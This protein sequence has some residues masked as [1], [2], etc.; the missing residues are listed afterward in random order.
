MKKILFAYD[1]IRP[2]QKVL[3]DDISKALLSHAHHLAHAPTGLGKTAASLAPAITYALEH[4]KV[5]FFLTSRHTQHT[6]AID[7]IR[8]IKQKHGVLIPTVDIIGRQKMCPV[9]GVQSLYSREFNE[10]CK[11][12]RADGTC[13]FYTNTWT[14]KGTLTASA[15]ASLGSL[16]H[17][18]PLHVEELSKECAKSKLCPYE[19]SL[20]LAKK[21]RVIVADYYYLFNPNI[22]DVLLARIN[23]SLQDCIVIVDEAHNL[24]GRI[25]E[26]MT[27]RISL[28]SIRRAQKEAQKH[29]YGSLAIFLENLYRSFVAFGK[30]SHHA[31]QLIS[32][33]LLISEVQS[34]GDYE[35]VIESLDDAAAEVRKNQKQS[36]L[37]SVASFLED[38]QGSDEGY[39]R[40]LSR[41]SEG[42]QMNVVLSY[43]C[44]DPSLVSND[45]INQSH[46]LILMSGTLTPVDMYKDILGF[47][48]DATTGE[49]ASPFSSKNRL[50][51]VNPT[52]TTK[53]SSR[54]DAEFLRIAT[55]CSEITDSI[56]GNSVIFF[57]SYGIKDI[58]W[59][60]LMRI[61]KKTMFQETKNLSKDER[62]DLLKEFKAYSKKGAVL[63]AVA[64]GSFGE[65]IDLPGDYLKGVVVVGLPL[66]PP[67][68]TVKQLIDYYQK[69]F[70]RG[71]DY[72]YTLPAITKSL[73][74]AGRCIRTEKDRG[75]IVFLEKRF[76][77]PQYFRCFPH[78][79]DVKITQDQAMAIK[80]FFSG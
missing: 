42:Q 76:S 48:D 32:K 43:Q 36:S 34:Y 61:S 57:P 66:Q 13:E 11:A 74:N 14:G 79:W 78:D 41:Q 5:V 58:V 75:V 20:S 23:R 7:T 28:F 52:V 47:S 3:L 10:Y 54:C 45:V 72:G 59:K 26:L 39:A 29:N 49:Y 25:R 65:G 67:D 16:K 71:W 70:N 77:L 62:E 69:R 56:P 6:I 35:K 40:I 53:Y 2:A 44:L 8:M 33:D 55:A 80:D 30:S 63:L 1:T 21:A 18:E 38:W 73:Q 9:G 19:L 46:S 17:V 68:L 64:A 12:V 22:R 60:H 27:Q 4:D 31:E 15:K 50:V 24:P 51:L 37:G